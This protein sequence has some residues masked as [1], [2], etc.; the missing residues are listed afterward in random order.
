LI[1]GAAGFC[2]FLSKSIP[3]ASIPCFL[4]AADQLAEPQQSSMAF[5]VYFVQGELGAVVVVP[6]EP[7]IGKG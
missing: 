2:G 4:I 7:D 5:A 1:I 3:I 6:N